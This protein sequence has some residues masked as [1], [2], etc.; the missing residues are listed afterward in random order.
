MAYFLTGGASIGATA[1]DVAGFFGVTVTSQPA[2]TAQS[3][4]VTTALTA[5]TAGE[6]LVGAISLINQLITRAEAIRVYVAQTRLD[7]IAL[8]AQKGS[9]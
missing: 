4:I 3:A 8:G 2:A 7:L 9:A 6:T 5:L 1:A